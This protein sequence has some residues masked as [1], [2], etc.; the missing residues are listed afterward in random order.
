MEW[1]DWTAVQPETTEAV[2]YKLSLLKIMGQTFHGWT[3][4]KVEWSWQDLIQ[5]QGVS[6]FVFT[7]FSSDIVGF[8]MARFE[9]GSHPHSKEVS[10]QQA[11]GVLQWKEDHKTGSEGCEDSYKP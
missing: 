11:S 2:C 6:I 7:F 4:A 9:L 5:L 10:C 3:W 1:E 8:F